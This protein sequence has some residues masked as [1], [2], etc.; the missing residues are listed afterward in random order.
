MRLGDLDENPSKAAHDLVGEPHDPTDNE[1][2]AFSI[3]GVDVDDPQLRGTVF[4]WVDKR[5]GRL[6]V[7]GA[8]RL[9]LT[10]EEVQGLVAGFEGPFLEWMNTGLKT[11]T[12]EEQRFEDAYAT[13]VQAVVEFEPN[14]YG[15]VASSVT[16]LLKGLVQGARERMMAAPG[17]PV[18]PAA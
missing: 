7:P 1:T 17:K 9:E 3:V 12:L 16:G 6:Q 2:R 18:P 5:V 11:D 4:D 13:Y 14:P 8:T 10:R 15:C